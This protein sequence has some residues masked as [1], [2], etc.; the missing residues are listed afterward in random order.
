MTVSFTLRSGPSNTILAGTTLAISPTLFLFRYFLNIK[1]TIT[2]A[3]IAETVQTK[4]PASNLLKTPIYA[5]DAASAE[6]K[7]I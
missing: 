7:L 6:N 1:P 2:P 4:N 5:T 3:I